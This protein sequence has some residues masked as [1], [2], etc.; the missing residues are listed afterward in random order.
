MCARGGA[1]RVF[2]PD[3]H[4]SNGV[5]QM[6]EPAPGDSQSPKPWSGSS[7]PS[8]LLDVFGGGSSGAQEALSCCHDKLLII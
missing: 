3:K 8:A 5:V 4:C 6:A 1:Y 2:L 7:W